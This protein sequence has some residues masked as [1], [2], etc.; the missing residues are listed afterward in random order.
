[1]VV[2]VVTVE[3]SSGSGSGSSSGGGFMGVSAIKAIRTCLLVSTHCQR[4][5]KHTCKKS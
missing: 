2:L 3:G 4:M 1:V 5:I